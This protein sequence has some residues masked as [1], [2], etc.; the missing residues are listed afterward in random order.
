MCN[1]IS[2]SKVVR[3][4]VLLNLDFVTSLV[5]SIAMYIAML[6]SVCYATATCS[7]SIVLLYIVP[8]I[9]S[10][11]QQQY[12]FSAV[13]HYLERAV[14]SMCIDMYIYSNEYQIKDIHD[15]LTEMSPQASI[16]SNHRSA[17]LMMPIIIIILFLQCNSLSIIFQYKT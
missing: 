14:I 15:Q 6:P 12:S 16:H 7:H 9:C 13:N 8:H 5:I 10:L 1:Y 4:M 3:A 2:C 17:V 11:I